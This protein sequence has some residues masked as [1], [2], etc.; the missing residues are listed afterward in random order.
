MSVIQVSLLCGSTVRQFQFFA[1]SPE[2]EQQIREY[3]YA[4]NNVVKTINGIHFTKEQLTMAEEAYEAYCEGNMPKCNE[5]Y[6]KILED[7]RGHLAR[8]SQAVD[9]QEAVAALCDYAS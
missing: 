8:T 2:R 9:V 4:A 7:L 5:I 1:D 3:W 6:V